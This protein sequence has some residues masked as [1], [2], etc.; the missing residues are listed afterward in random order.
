MKY[1]NGA[2]KI[3][4]TVFRHFIDNF[5]QSLFYL[6]T[7]K[8]L[9]IYH[10]RKLFQLQIKSVTKCSWCQLDTFNYILKFLLITL[11]MG[12]CLHAS[13]VKNYQVGK[14]FASKN[15]AG[16]PKDAKDIPEYKGTNIPE[17]NLSHGNIQDAI[18][19]KMKEKDNAGAFINE[20]HDKRLRFNIDPLKDPIFT[21]SDKIVANPMDTLKVK[22]TEIDEPV[23]ETKSRHICEEGGSD[24]SLTCTRNL[25]IETVKKE[26]KYHRSHLE[27]VIFKRY[28]VNGNP[29]YTCSYVSKKG[30]DGRY[31]L[32]VVDPSLKD[33]AWKFHDGC[34]PYGHWVTNEYSYFKT[35]PGEK[36]TSI[37]KQEYESKVLGKKDIR[38]KWTSD[39]G[40][41]EQKVD[42]G[43]CWYVSKTCT[44]KNQTRTINGSAVTRPCWQETM[45]YQ[46]SY[47]VK[48][49]CGDLKAKGCVQVAS[50]CKHKISNTCV[51]YTQ[52]YECTERKGGG[53]KTKISGDAPWCLDGNCTEQGFAANKDMAEAL[54]KLMIFREIQKDMDVKGPTV[55]KGTKYGCNR[56]CVNFKDCCGSGNGW[57][58]SLG[59]AGCSEKEKALAQLRQDKKCVYVGTYCAEE[60]P[61]I[62]CIRKKSNFCCF[63][64]RLARLIHEQGRPQL[65]MGFGNAEH[66]Q[67]RGF[68]VEELTKLNFD[69]I[70]LSE[71][72]SDLY[73]K[74]KTPN[75][76]KLSQDFS[77]DWKKRM[78]GIQK[79]DKR[80]IDRIREKG[81]QTKE[82]RKDAAF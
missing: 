35:F 43:L 10:F 5:N 81:I 66:P 58:V 79:D 15:P 71:L 51:H 16:Q 52:T 41:I 34:N 11:V 42:Q 18:T 3:R 54:S 24:Y 25:Q 78:P 48:N 20:S 31:N 22:V 77:Q 74:F 2:I 56:N 65:K 36:Q 53:K 40:L 1:E 73:S 21:E 39:C 12:S 67:C 9:I 57:G 30:H 55:F 8:N 61:I 38:E 60:A 68:T 46:C 76:S 23:T 49:T 4:V 27:G 14:D 72:L 29:Q 44:Q 45:T 70:D 69:K 13:E 17:A 37:T 7:C 32:Y 59:L 19:K 50:Q 82:G 47:P 80:Y 33:M 62:G 6:I 26:R 64:T 63:G 28:R 75:L